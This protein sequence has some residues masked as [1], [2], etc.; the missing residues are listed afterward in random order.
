MTSV[1]IRALLAKSDGRLCMRLFRRT[2]GTVI[3]KDCPIGLRAYRKRVASVATAALASVLGL[4]SIS[5]GQDKDAQKVDASKV[6]ITR[7]AD[8]TGKAVLHGMVTDPNGAVIPGMSVQLF[9]KDGKSPIAQ[10]TSNETGEY[11]FEVPAGVYEIRVPK[12]GGFAAYI[13]QNVQ[14]TANLTTEANLVITPKQHTVV[15]IGVVD[16]SVIDMS[17]NE[18]KTVFTREMLDLM[19]GGRPF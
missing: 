7:S 19:P 11:S 8:A 9:Q 10:T 13:R 6:Q 14:L 5:Y 15:L 17:S 12:K 16:F 2:D 4:F 18:R 3:T 1:E